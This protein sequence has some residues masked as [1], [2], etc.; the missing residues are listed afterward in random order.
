MLLKLSR[1]AGKSDVFESV[2]AFSPA[3]GQLNEFAGG[4]YS[5][6]LDAAYTMTVKNERLFVINRTGVERP[7]LPTF[8]DAFSTL[9]LAQFEFSRDAQGKVSGFVVHAGRIRN[10]RFARR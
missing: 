2:E 8:R 7:L 6:E 4:Y 5:E 10:V 1:S 9:S 3:A